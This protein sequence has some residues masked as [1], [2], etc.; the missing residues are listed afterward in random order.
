MHLA[1]PKI[2]QMIEMEEDPI[3][4]EAIW[5]GVIITHFLKADLYR[6]HIRSTLHRNNMPPDIKLKE[7]YD[8]TPRKIDLTVNG[9][10][11]T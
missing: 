5:R 8:V 1:L 3:K 7:F 9:I 11:F 10:D 6:R 4:K 2:Q